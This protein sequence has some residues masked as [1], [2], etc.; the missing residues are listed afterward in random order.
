MVK[1]GVNEY[2][3]FTV[4]LP[5]FSRMDDL[6]EF[7]FQPF[8]T[9]KL[10]EIF[11]SRAKRNVEVYESLENLVADIT[12]KSVGSSSLFCFYLL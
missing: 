8:L 1:N 12:R 11:M 7:G 10:S 4:F 3:I 9:L 5:L 6:F 2:L